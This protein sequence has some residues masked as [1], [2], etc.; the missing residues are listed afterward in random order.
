MKR[1]ILI[2]FLTST[3]T[4]TPTV[5]T[6]LFIDD[7]TLEYSTGTHENPSTVQ[8]DFTLD[9]NYP[10]P[11]NPTTTISYKLPSGKDEYLLP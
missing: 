5:G 4:H 7:I 9:Q 1:I 10:N 8:Q 11:F 6:E 2:G 3:M